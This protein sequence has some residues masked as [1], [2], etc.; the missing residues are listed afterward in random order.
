[1]VRQRDEEVGCARFAHERGHV[2]QCLL[3]GREIRRLDQP[4]LP[5][6]V[7]VAAFLARQGREQ[8][9]AAALLQL[10]VQ[11]AKPAIFSATLVVADDAIPVESLVVELLDETLVGIVR[12]V[13]PDHQIRA[14]ARQHLAQALE[15]LPGGRAAGAEPHHLDV[16][17]AAAAQLAFEL[18]PPDVVHV[19][20]AI[21]P[22]E[23]VADDHDAMRLLARLGRREAA[24]TPDPLVRRQQDLGEVVL[25]D[26]RVLLL[27]ASRR[28]LNARPGVGRSRRFDPRENPVIDDRERHGRETEEAG[29]AS[30]RVAPA[31]RLQRALRSAARTL[32]A[33]R[34]NQVA[35]RI[36][37]HVG[38]VAAEAAADR[39]RRG[40]A[41]SLAW[42]FGGLQLQR[43]QPARRQTTLA[44]DRRR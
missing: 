17:V 4:Q 13:A 39:P 8:F 24:R 14:M 37:T 21:A 19:G 11:P 20:V 12:D 42:A 22:D 26:A 1:M 34:R 38:L 30:E 35:R 3:V 9:L 44:Y 18:S 5:F 29:E 2:P 43:P 7:F 41:P 33:P 40:G 15:F 25:V 28:Q 6:V 31:S 16:G 36:V 10:E 23:G 32:L 27:P